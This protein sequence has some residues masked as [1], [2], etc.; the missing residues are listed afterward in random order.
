LRLYTKTYLY[1]G[2]G[3][4]GGGGPSPAKL[5]F[6]RISSDIGFSSYSSPPAT[7]SYSSTAAA[8]AT[9]TLSGFSH[10]N[11]SGAPN[12]GHLPP[13]TTTTIEYT[14]AALAAGSPPRPPI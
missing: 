4:G 6:S 13:G 8:A 14:P 3:G 5:P 12:N 11:P 9:T 10:Q 2:G 7:R 1:D